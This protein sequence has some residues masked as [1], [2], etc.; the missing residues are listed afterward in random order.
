MGYRGVDAE[1][2]P[3][4]PE[5]LTLG[6]AARYLG[7]AQ[8]TIRKWTDVGRL[9]AFKTPGGHR[10]YRRRDLD[11][12][13]ERSQPGEPARER[14][15]LIVDR[16]PGVR[17]AVR[18]SLEA[19][20]CAVREAETAEQGLAVL[21]EQLPD[22]VLLDVMM[23]GTEGWEVLRRVQGRHGLGA[24]PVVMFS[25]ELDERF[26]DEG[27]ARGGDELAREPFDPQQLV[28]SAKQMLS[29]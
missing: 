22:L 12:F 14:L 19:E 21:E 16:D 4:E 26:H 2:T 17:G 24:V 15:I 6:Q 10:R 27:G 20:G 1:R 23:P 13:L 18:A 9:P 3:S 7:V 8:S 29:S 25:G 5:W 28:A 11:A